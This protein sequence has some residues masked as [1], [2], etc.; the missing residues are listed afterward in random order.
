MRVVTIPDWTVRGV[1]PPIDEQNPISPERSPYKVSLADIIK[2][3]ATSTERCNILDGFLRYRE[4]LQKLG[5]IDGFQWL[6]GSFMESV[7]MLEQRVPKDVDVVTFFSLNNGCDQAA[8]IRQNPWLVDLLQIKKDF[9]VDG[10]M[11]DMRQSPKVLIERSAYWYSLWSHRRNQLWKG[12]LQ[13]DLSA[14]DD[15]AAKN[16]LENIRLKQ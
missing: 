12:Y 11:V 5:F 6:N 3:F 14:T 16:V 2:K 7:E 4:S 8:I 1:L 13:V 15:A 10:Y 9:C